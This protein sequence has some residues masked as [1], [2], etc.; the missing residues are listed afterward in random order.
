[1]VDAKPSDGA[2]T[3]FARS[4][5]KQ[6]LQVKP[7]EH[8]MI[9]A[10]T[11]TVPWAVALA[12]EARAMGAHPL[13]TYEDEDAYWAAIDGGK[14]NLLGTAAQHEWAALAKTDVYIHMWGPG[15]RVRLNALPER[16][17]GAAF[18]FNDDW[19]KTARKA[20]LRGARLEIGRPYPTLAKAYD[21][22]ESTWS[23]QLA[24]ATMVDPK[25]L[26][27]RAAP[28][29]KALAKG[30]RLTISHPNGTRLTLGLA[31]YTPRT[32]V[33][34]PVVGDKSRP[35]DLLANLPSGAI[36][37]ALDE[38]VADGTIVGNRTCYYDDGIATEPTFEFE[39]GRLTSAHYASGGDRF[40]TPYAK[41]GKGRDQPG[42]L[43]IGLNSELH[44]TPQ[45]EDIEA[46][47]VMVSVG[48]NRQLGGKNSS[49]LFGWSIVARPT[50]EVDGKPLPLPM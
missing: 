45:V 42:F 4:V 39:N 36:R 50:L 19:Y 1:M 15:D 24:A 2:A 3:Q 21:F 17:A 13:V 7:G 27:R 14:A 6:N 46:G 38:K 16:K 23:H 29:E 31:G 47:A 30:K 37:V 25:E 9:E 20:G 48:G 11:H 43:A 26:A 22:D 32:Q 49:S 8:V 40:D 5:L 34:R 44:N 33:G 12:Q 18:R 35:F 28:I 41:G 10:W